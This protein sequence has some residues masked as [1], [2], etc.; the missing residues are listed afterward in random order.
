MGIYFGGIT[1]YKRN[2][3]ANGFEA[4]AYGFMSA[5]AFQRGYFMPTYCIPCP[6]FTYNFSPYRLQ[7]QDCYDYI[8]FSYK[9]YS[10]PVYNEPNYTKYRYD[11]YNSN[12][13]Y[14]FTSYPTTNRYTYKPLF[15]CKPVTANN[16]TVKPKSNDNTN[17]KEVNLRADTEYTGTAKDLNKGLGGV[18]SGKGDVF[19]KAQ[20]KYGVNAAILAS[21]CRLESDNGKSDN[22]KEKNNVAGIRIAGSY[23]FRK[24][25]SV[26]DCIMYTAKLLKNS[27]INEGLITL[28]QIGGKYCP[29]KD[30]TDKTGENKYWAER[31]YGV[32]KKLV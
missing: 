32:Y 17:P 13:Y 10:S 20:E 11:N 15:D 31:V 3:F 14:D 28:S 25:D 8:P 23:E 27:Y 5:Y 16:K 9:S 29:I 21:I 22:A 30:K 26:E 24:F 1:P 7:V 6:Q 12:N 4:F 2:N 19:I 18:L